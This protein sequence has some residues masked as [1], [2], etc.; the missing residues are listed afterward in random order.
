MSLG[1]VATDALENDLFLCMATVERDHELCCSVIISKLILTYGRLSTLD[2]TEPIFF[3]LDFAP[4]EATPPPRK[5]KT[6]AD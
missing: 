5:D 3:P 6:P 4:L 1:S 2:A